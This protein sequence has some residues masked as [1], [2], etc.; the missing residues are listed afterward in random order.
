M[1]RSLPSCHEIAI[2]KSCTHLRA[3]QQLIASTHRA[4]GMKA[5]EEIRQYQS[6]TKLLIKKAPFARLVREICLD[7]CARG[8]EIRWQSNAILAIQEA[9]EHY[10]VRLFEDTN[11]CAI[12][13]KRVTIKPKDI[14][15]ENFKIVG[16]TWN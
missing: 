16:Y 10:L 5:L 8:V 2:Q 11:L 7:V 4:P 15:P 13:A 1:F 6:T 3:K 9:S 14:S 12:H